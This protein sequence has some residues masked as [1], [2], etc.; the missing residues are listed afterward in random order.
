MPTIFYMLQC[1]HIEAETKWPP[2][3][4]RHFQLQFLELENKKF[5]LDFTEVCSQLSNQQY[6]NIGSNNGLAPARQQAI[7]WT[8]D[9]CFT[10]AYMHRSASVC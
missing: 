3:A 7:S 1:Y 2:F 9:G 10:D 6:Y 5:D 8:N 4:W